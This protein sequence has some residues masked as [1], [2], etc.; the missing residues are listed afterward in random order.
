MIFVTTS[1]D[2]GIGIRTITANTLAD[3]ADQLRQLYGGGGAGFAAPVTIAVLLPQFTATVTP[4]NPPTI[5]FSGDSATQQT[6]RNAAANALSNNAAYLALANP[7]NAQ[8]VAQVS[9]LTR[10]VDGLIR[11]AV[12]NFAGT[13]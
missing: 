12:G 5:T 10:Q 1:D 8:V 7:N 9:A 6:I 11:L 4:G 13:A 2:A 3:A